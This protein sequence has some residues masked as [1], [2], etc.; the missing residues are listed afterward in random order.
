MENKVFLIVG[1]GNYIDASNRLYR[2]AKD[3]DLKMDVV[4]V[5]EKKII[6][7]FKTDNL[8]CSYLNRS[9]RGFGFWIWKPVVINYYLKTY[10]QVIYIDA[11]SE[12]L[13]GPFIN[14]M[15]WFDVS[16][17]NLVL[18]PSGQIMKAYTKMDS[19][20][21]F[22]S[23]EEWDTLQ[24]FPMLQ[25]G[26]L[27]IKKT[28]ENVQLF[29]ILTDLVKSNRIDLFDDFNRFNVN[30]EFFIDHRHDQSVFNLVFYKYFNSNKA[31]LFPSS[32]TPPGQNI[33]FNSLPAILC[34]RNVSFLSYINNYSLFGNQSNF[35][36]TLK[37]VSRL[38]NSLF[39]RFKLTHEFVDVMFNKI[40][41]LWAF[42]FYKKTYLKFKKNYLILEKFDNWPKNII[43]N[44]N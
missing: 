36:L 23:E 20:Y 17:F 8:S 19:V 6:D 32:L 38:F 43:F 34:L 37:I 7:I 4:I 15:N 18:S 39:K 35:P 12:I 22:F 33:G 11:G 25:A 13:K 29:N 30:G 9:I 3:L 24:E 10:D 5:N 40:C 16:C 21:E 1:L 26:V 27:F 44:N 2:Q 31:I 28:S 41:L 42:V 14:L